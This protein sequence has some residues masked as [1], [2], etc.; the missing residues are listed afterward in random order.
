MNVGKVVEHFRSLRPDLKISDKVIDGT[1]RHTRTIR[2]ADATGAVPTD[3]CRCTIARA[4]R[5][6]RDVAEALI[7]TNV[8]YLL[9][10]RGRRYIVVKYL[11][12]GANIVKNTDAG[13]FPIWRTP[14]TLRPPSQY[15]RVG[16]QTVSQKAAMSGGK[17]QTAE[18]VRKRTASA[19][20]SPARVRMSKVGAA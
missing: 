11:H 15:R 4:F 6:E 19:Q 17:K 16:A 13:A 20:S 12:D 2:R 14:I 3:P 10:R 9:E 7:L 5:K 18:H 8:A 1:E